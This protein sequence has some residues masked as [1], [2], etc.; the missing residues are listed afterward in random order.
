MNLVDTPTIKYTDLRHGDALLYIETKPT[1][2]DK[3]IQVITGSNCIHV[4]MVLFN[5]VFEQVLHRRMVP[6]NQYSNYLA[7]GEIILALRPKFNIAINPDEINT[8]SFYGFTGILD[9]LMNHLLGR[10]IPRYK[11]TAFLTRIWGLDCSGLVA[12]ILNLEHNC[13]WCHDYRVV[14]PDDFMNHGE[15][16]DYLG[17]VEW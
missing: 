17:R 6:L 1:W 8:S 7:D 9:Q 5:N 13:D 10:L 11:H 12:N 4:S 15:S 3:G 14:E 2:I 16:F